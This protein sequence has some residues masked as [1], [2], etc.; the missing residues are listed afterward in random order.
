MSSPSL[1]QWIERPPGVQEVIRFDSCRGLTFF[2][3]IHACV[4]L[5]QVPSWLLNKLWFFFL[6]ENRPSLQSQSGDLKYL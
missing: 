6:K 3:L 2:S 1:V 4:M 5:I